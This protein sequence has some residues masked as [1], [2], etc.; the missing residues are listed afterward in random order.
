MRDR[1]GLATEPETREATDNAGRLE[2]TER[3]EN[4]AATFR[5]TV[6]HNVES[7]G[8]K[9]EPLKEGCGSTHAWASKPAKQLLR[10]VD[11]HQQPEHKSRDK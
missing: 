3:E 1:R 4:A 5:D 7:A 10:A 8:S 9:P 2:E 6:S 11:G